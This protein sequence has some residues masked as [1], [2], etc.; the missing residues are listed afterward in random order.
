ML[1]FCIP[2]SA[3]VLKFDAAFRRLELHHEELFLLLF[4]RVSTF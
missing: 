4:E 2:A 3:D 1:S